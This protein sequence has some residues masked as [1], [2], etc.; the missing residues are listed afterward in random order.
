MNT[1]IIKKSGIKKGMTLARAGLVLHVYN[2]GRSAEQIAD[3]MCEDI[4]DIEEI[5]GR[6]KD[7]TIPEPPM[8]LRSIDDVIG[9][10]EYL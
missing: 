6:R 10:L 9:G 1:E 8:V 3:F 2:L 4:C 5:I 7:F